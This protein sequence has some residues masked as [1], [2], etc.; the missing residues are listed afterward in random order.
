MMISNR[1]RLAGYSA[2]NG[3]FKTWDSDPMP[4][5]VPDADFIKTLGK[6][7]NYY[8]L[9]ERYDE[10]YDASQ[11]VKK[12]MKSAADNLPLSD[13][14]EISSALSAL[15]EM[16]DVEESLFAQ[17]F[18]FMRVANIKELSESPKDVIVNL[19]QGFTYTSRLSTEE[20]QDVTVKKPRDKA[21]I[22]Q[23]VMSHTT[24]SGPESQLLFEAIRLMA[25]IG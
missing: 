15:S 8:D 13:Q 21:K 6:V 2:S 24:L 5:N 18:Q 9:V 16:T 20:K 22:L 19:I 10:Y 3:F 11:Q 25:N 4:L 14:K 1:F 23:D 17:G 7:G 12:M